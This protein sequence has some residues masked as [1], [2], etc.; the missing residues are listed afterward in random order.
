MHKQTIIRRVKASKVFN[1]RGSPMIEAI[2]SN[3]FGHSINDLRGA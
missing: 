3:G 1:S 2:T